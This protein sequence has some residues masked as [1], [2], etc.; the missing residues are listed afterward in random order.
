MSSSSAGGQ[1][2]AL[3]YI[4]LESPRGEVDYVSASTAGVRGSLLQY[5]LGITSWPSG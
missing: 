5:C 2:V 1:G 3:A 4:V